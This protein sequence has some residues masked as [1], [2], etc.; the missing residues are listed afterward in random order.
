MKHVTNRTWMPDDEEP[1]NRNVQ[2]QGF[3]GEGRG[4]IKTVNRERQRRRAKQLG[5]PFPD[6]RLMKRKRRSREEQKPSC[7]VLAVI[8][9]KYE[10]LRPAPAA[11]FR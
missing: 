10:S 6:D 7:L 5:S 1:T 8:T 2:E 4:C 3:G 9:G 11:G